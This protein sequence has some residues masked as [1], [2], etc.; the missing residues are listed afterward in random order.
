MLMQ[1]HE[2]VI[3]LFPVWNSARNAEFMNLRAYGAF[4]VSASMNNGSITSAEIYSEKGNHCVL[5]SP[6]DNVRITCD[7][8]TVPTSEV[9]E[10]YGITIYFDTKPGYTYKIEHA[11]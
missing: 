9:S 1:S 3:R 6:C 7:G 2:G 11:E 10:H 8:N 5:L 4:L